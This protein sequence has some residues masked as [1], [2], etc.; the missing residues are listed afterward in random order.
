MSVSIF[1]PSLPP[2]PYQNSIVTGSL[3][4]AAASAA[5]ADDA[6]LASVTSLEAVFP[7]QA[8]STVNPAIMD[9]ADNLFN[10]FII[11]LLFV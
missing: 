2:S 10:T 1:S 3:G 7:P 8:V 9:I 11:I 4:A 6:P 5:G